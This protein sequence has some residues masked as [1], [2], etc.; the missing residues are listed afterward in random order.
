MRTLGPLHHSQELLSSY[1]QVLNAHT[2]K[3]S[4]ELHA[5][6]KQAIKTILTHHRILHSSVQVRTWG[7]TQAH[8]SIS[9]NLF[10]ITVS[11]NR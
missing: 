3:I 7:E 5:Y 9:Q 4:Y 11:E 6:Y 1:F 10:I 8:C 2:F